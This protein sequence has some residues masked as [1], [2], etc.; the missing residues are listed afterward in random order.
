MAHAHRPYEPFR[1]DCVTELWRIISTRKVREETALFLK[2]VHSLIGS[3]FLM[4]VGEPEGVEPLVGDALDDGAIEHLQGLQ[5]R[6]KA[7]LEDGIPETFGAGA[8]EAI[9]PDQILLIIQVVSMVIDWIKKR[10]EER[11]G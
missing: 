2:E 4:F 1:L 6:C 8:E 11:R 9:T 5:D 7:A 3:G 10:R